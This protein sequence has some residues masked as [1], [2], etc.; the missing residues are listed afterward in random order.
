MNMLTNLENTV[1]EIVSS[2]PSMTAEEIAELTNSNV[3][4][5]DGVLKSISKAGLLPGAH[6]ISPRAEMTLALAVAGGNGNIT[7][8]VTR[9]YASAKPV[10]HA[11]ECNSSAYSDLGRAI[12]CVSCGAILAGPDGQ[13]KEGTLHDIVS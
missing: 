7:P 5:V 12:E 6:G 2:A 13:L 8:A 1:L 3:K 4:R 9:V 11:P 10:V